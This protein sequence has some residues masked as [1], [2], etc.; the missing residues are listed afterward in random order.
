MGQ[1]L[2]V[3]ESH[4]LKSVGAHF[5]IHTWTLTELSQFVRLRS[6][7]KTVKMRR[8]SPVQLLRSEVIIPAF[9]GVI[10]MNMHY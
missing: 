2:F 8:I 10:S 5:A 7:T 1:R 6:Q 3:L 9:F 4:H